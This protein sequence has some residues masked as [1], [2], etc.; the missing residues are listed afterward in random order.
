MK[1]MQDGP[2]TPSELQEAE[3]LWL[4]EAQTSLHS[5]MYKKE[6]DALSPFLDDKGVIRVG[7]R[8]DNAV[9]TYESRHSA[10][11]PYELRISL[12]ITRHMH[13]C[14]HSGVASTTAKI[15]ARYWILKASKLTNSVKLKCSFCREMARKAETQQMANLPSLRLALFTPPFHYTA[16]DYFEPFKV[17]DGRNKTAKHYGVIF[18]C[19]NTR[20]VPL[21]M[22]VDCSTMEFM[23]VLR[24]FF[25]IRGYP[26][27]M[28][29]DNGSQMV[30]AA[31]ELREMLE[32]LDNY[33]LP[34]FCAEKGIEWEFTTPAS[35]HQNGCTEALVKTGKSALKGAIGEQVLT[36]LELYTYLLEVA[37]L[38]NQRPI[39]TI[40]N[41]PDD[42]A[43]ICPNN[44]LLG[45]TTSLVSQGPFKETRNPRHRVEFVQR[46]VDSFWKRW[47]RDVFPT[48]VPKRKWREER[49]N[50]RIGDVV[51]VADENAV[52]G[53]EAMGRITDVFPGADGKV[54]K[55]KVKTS[56]GVY[57]RPVTKIAVI[58]PT[59][60]Y[61]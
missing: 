48:L 17:K 53:S 43:Y 1:Q 4:K 18:T 37:N 16:C 52:R 56:K 23:Q 24:R 19:L 45:R 25:S 6:F 42:R 20:A 28:M 14:G 38:V 55:V 40:P 12:L 46:I 41:D 50:V 59:E 31:R 29:S 10:L 30:G 44:M 60:G 26:S 47:N 27:V 32:G 61:D 3:T 34:E 7:G 49:R 33:Q 36:P 9:V 39:G 15:R 2:L 57:R 54:R 13:Q 11:L 21:E 35:P 5:R 8:V 58:Y 22:A 51:T